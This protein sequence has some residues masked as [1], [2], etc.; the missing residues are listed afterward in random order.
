MEISGMLFSAVIGHP[1]QIV[2]GP[3]TSTHGGHSPA[4]AKQ[5]HKL[6]KPT[7]SVPL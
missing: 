2:T 6:F 7:D 4:L 3:I 1:T 5:V